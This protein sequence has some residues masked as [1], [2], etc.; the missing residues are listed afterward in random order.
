MFSPE[1]PVPVRLL[2][3][4]TVADTSPLTGNIHDLV[5]LPPARED[6]AAA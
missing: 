6:L 2:E 5:T 3:P 1:L 4:G